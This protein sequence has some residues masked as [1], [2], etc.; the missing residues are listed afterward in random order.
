MWN[1]E[2]Q[3]G[4]GNTPPLFRDFTRWNMCWRNIRITEG[5]QIFLEKLKKK[6]QSVM[7]RQQCEEATCCRLQRRGILLVLI[8]RCEEKARKSEMSHHSFHGIKLLF[9]WKAPKWTFSCEKPKITQS[10]REKKAA[11]PKVTPPMSQAELIA[12]QLSCRGE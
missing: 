12:V 3:D 5:A 9:Q 10:Q 1:N 11:S 6:T 7:K 8:S 2:R 4:G